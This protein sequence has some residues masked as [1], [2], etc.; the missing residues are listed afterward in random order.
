MAVTLNG[1]RI[2]IPDVVARFAAYYEHPGNDAWGSLHIVLSDGNTRACDAAFCSEWAAEN[3]DTE[4]VELAN[5]LVMMTASQRGR[6]S[7][8]VKEYLCRQKAV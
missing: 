8:K 5:M 7:R 2:R 3:F 1:E 6:L 4:G